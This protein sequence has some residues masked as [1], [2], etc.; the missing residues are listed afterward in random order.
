MAVAAWSLRSRI[1]PG[2]TRP[3][4]GKENIDQGG[5]AARAEKI[6]ECCGNL[7]EEKVRQTTSFKTI[8]GFP[9]M[10]L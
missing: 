9:D 3:P 2:G 1:A 6:V 8:S 7:G 10:K 5:L 4:P